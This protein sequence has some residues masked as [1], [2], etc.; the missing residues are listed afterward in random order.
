MITLDLAHLLASTSEEEAPLRRTLT[1]ISHNVAKSKKT[2]VVSGAGISCSCGIP[3]FRSSD[4]LYNLVKARYPSTFVTG[5]D[6]FSS[7]LFRSPDSTSLFYSFIAELKLAVSAAEPS[8]THRFIKKLDDKGKLMRS[9]TQNIDGMEKRVGMKC[10]TSVVSSASSGGGG[11]TM[12]KKLTKNIQ[13]HGDIHR[14]R[15]MVCSASYEFTEEYVEMFREGDAPDCP[16]CQER[17][18]DRIARSKRPLAAGVLRPA[19]VLYDENHPNGDL[20]GSIQTHDI[21]RTPDLLLVLG[22]SLKVHGLKRLVKELARGVR[23]LPVTAARPNGGRGRVVFVNKTPPQGAEWK[24]VFDYWVKGECDEWVGR[25]EEEWRKVKKGDW[26]VQATL[27][28]AQVVKVA[29]VG[30]VKAK[31]V[32]GIPKSKGESFFLR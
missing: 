21:T 6:L 25:V 5:K 27:D 20:I 17:T 9:Y 28:G 2:V 4:G 1:S 19:I 23:S 26:E 22:T 15:C 11:V 7:S 8:A 12:D 31:K 13:L 24:G 29:S 32:A 18:Q 14:V 3:D 16:A 10:S 30:G